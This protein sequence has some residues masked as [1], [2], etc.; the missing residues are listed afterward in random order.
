MD[1]GA[2]V[3]GFVES[4]QHFRSGDCY[5]IDVVPGFRSD[6]SLC[7][8]GPVSYGR[9]MATLIGQCGRVTV[10]FDCWRCDTDSGV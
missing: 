7:C 8:C 3:E 5:T 10:D 9:E 6:S 2:L 4:A 1:S